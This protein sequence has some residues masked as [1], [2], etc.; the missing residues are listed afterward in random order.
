MQTHRTKILFLFVLLAAIAAFLSYLQLDKARAGALGGE[1]DLTIVHRNLTDIAQVNVGGPHI[2]VGELDAAELTRRLTAAAV[3]AGVL[4]HLVDKESSA[5][6]R[7]EKSEYN[8]LQITLRFDK[9][10]MRQ[11]TIFFDRLAATDP[12]SRVKTVELSPPEV[13]GAFPSPGA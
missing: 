6:T 11:L 2:A 9:I 4:D 10:S 3:D 12:G 7:L 5:P 1:R 13:L 8:D